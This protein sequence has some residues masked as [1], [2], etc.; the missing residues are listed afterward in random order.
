MESLF[1]SHGLFE[2]INEINV[3]FCP[4]LFSRK[5]TSTG[6]PRSRACT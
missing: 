2:P 3:Q 1:Y 5:R 4:C 6:G